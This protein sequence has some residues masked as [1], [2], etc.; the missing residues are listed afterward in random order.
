[1]LCK[2]ERLRFV[3]IGQLIHFLVDFGL[4]IFNVAIIGNRFAKLVS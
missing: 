4:E 1:M 2:T 3:L